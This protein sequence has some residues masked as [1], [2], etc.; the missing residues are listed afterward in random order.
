M[1][2]VLCHYY[3]YDCRNCSQ[4]GLNC[5][6]T[7]AIGFNY[8]L[9]LYSASR[10]GNS[11]GY[12]KLFLRYCDNE[13]HIDETLFNEIIDDGERM[14]ICK[15]LEK[16]TSHRRLENLV[17]KAGEKIIDENIQT[18]SI[19]ELFSNVKPTKKRKK[20][21]FKNGM[22]LYEIERILFKEL[23]KH[24]YVIHIWNDYLVNFINEI[25]NVKFICK[26]CKKIN[27]L[28]KENNRLK[29]LL[30]SDKFDRNLLMSLSEYFENNGL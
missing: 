17:E 28:E 21:E 10:L 20:M 8:K 14:Y 30:V 1:T 27:Q 2:C 3:S 6:E 11:T 29:L 4:C 26:T 25:R 5:C 12:Y 15:N 7:C 22:N 13:N 19:D 24:Y 23:L 16:P 18:C 9:F